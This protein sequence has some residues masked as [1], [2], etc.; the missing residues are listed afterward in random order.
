MEHSWLASV[1]RACH[2]ECGESPQ[3]FCYIL[4]SCI[5]VTLR[6]Q[7]VSPA[8]YV[9]NRSNNRSRGETG[10]REKNYI[11]VV[12]LVGSEKK[13][14][15]SFKENGSPSRAWAPY[16]PSNSRSETIDANRDNEMFEQ[17]LTFTRGYN[18]L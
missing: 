4:F 12:D 13:P 7:A 16:A 2:S 18:I 15:T 8:P 9:C 3:L 10:R 6:S 11:L 5:N 17:Y 14:C 1:Y